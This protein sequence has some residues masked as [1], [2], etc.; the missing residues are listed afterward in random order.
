MVPTKVVEFRS[1]FQ[2]E[3]IPISFDEMQR[4]E[5]SS[6][7]STPLN[8]STHSSPLSPPTPL[9]LTSSETI[10]SD[11]ITSEVEA[12]A[13]SIPSVTVTEAPLPSVRPS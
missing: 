1:R 13:P 2:G 8:I 7:P 12:V 9:P 11:P 10:H 4:S 5:S 3:Y 6:T